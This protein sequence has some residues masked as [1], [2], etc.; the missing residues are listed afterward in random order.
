LSILKIG[1]VLQKNG[2]ICRESSTVVEA[3]SS[4]VLR[5]AYC[6]LNNHEWTRIFTH[7]L[8]ATENAEKSYG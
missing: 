6:V 1:F 2:L 8:F 7:Y 3:I 4:C 5:T